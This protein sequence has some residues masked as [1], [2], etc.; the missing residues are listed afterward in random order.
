MPNNIIALSKISILKNTLI[1]VL[2]GV[3]LLSLVVLPAE[4]GIDP[5][6][7]GRLTGLVDL[8]S[9][10][11]KSNAQTGK[12]VAL[13]AQNNLE[14]EPFPEGNV[15]NH[16]GEPMSRS[17]KITLQPADEVEYK[18]LLQAGEPVFYYWS[19][20]NNEQ[21]YVDFHGDPTEGDFPEGYSQSYEAGEMAQSTGSFTATFTGNHGW[22][23]LNI[24]ESQIV[25]KLKITG[26]YDSLGEVYRGNQ[27]KTH[28]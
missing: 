15:N 2:L 23:W 7:F 21:V 24:S 18:A 3:L 25:I 11:G 1:S 27:M 14:D 16:D 26:Y 9:G 5:T 4:Y 28:N 19:V 12:D 10:A 17:V 8:S 22:Y 13:V 20:L 6:G